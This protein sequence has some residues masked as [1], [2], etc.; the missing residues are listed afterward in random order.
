MSNRAFSIKLANG[1]EAE[2]LTASEL[3]CFVDTCGASIAPRP[4][5][6]GKSKGARNRTKSK[7]TRTRDAQ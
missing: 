4:T 3:A 5:K 6:G 1:K 7:V 2:N